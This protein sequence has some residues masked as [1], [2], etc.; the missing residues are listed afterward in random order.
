MI[1]YMFVVVLG[2]FLPMLI[3]F[4]QKLQLHIKH[5]CLNL[6]QSAIP[7]RILKH[8]FSLG[9]VVRQRADGVRQ[10]L[11]ICS[12]GTAIAQCSKILARI[13]AMS[14]SITNRAC[15]SPICGFTSMSLSIIF[16]KFQMV[17]FA[18]F[19]N[20]FSVCIAPI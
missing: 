9:T 10:I 17:F 8:V 5:S 13:K 2:Y 12:Y 1:I 6:I 4:G 3:I 19:S 18:Y 15:N 16:N 7:T 20:L 14:G 11:V